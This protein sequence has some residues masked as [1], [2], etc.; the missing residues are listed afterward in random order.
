MFCP[1]FPLLRLHLTFL[2]LKVPSSSFKTVSHLIHH[3]CASQLLLFAEHNWNDQVRETEMGRIC[4]TNGVE[5]E[6]IQV[7]KPEG[8]IPL[9]TPRR[10]WVNNIKMDFRDIG[11][12]GMDWIDLAQD[13]DQWITLLN[14]VMNL[15]VP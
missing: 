4:S 7:E 1:F 15:R 8:K 12:G 5:E 13:R 3:S 9:G 6:C 2:L 10:R 14:A 11:W